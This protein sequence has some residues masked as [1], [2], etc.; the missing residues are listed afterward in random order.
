MIG[1]ILLFFAG[2]F[3]ITFSGFN[4]VP[5]S[6]IVWKVIMT[7]FINWLFFPLLWQNLINKSL[8]VEMSLVLFNRNL[9][10]FGNRLIGLYKAP[11]QN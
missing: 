11:K 5:N 6:E 2:T 7:R 8:K 4:P 1:L 9:D 10:I 3:G